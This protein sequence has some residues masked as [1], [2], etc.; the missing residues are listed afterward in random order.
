MNLRTTIDAAL[1]ELRSCSLDNDEDRERVAAVLLQRLTESEDAAH[2]RA[3]LG[4][5]PMQRLIR[6]H[7]AGGLRQARLLGAVA[8][9]VGLE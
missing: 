2:V 1:S 8:R 5:T 4:P 9:V 6:F 7:S 3:A